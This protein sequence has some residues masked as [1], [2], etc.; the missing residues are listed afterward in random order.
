MEKNTQPFSYIMTVIWTN[1]W[2]AQ[3][4]KT[5][6]KARKFLSSGIWERTHPIC[7]SILP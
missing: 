4:N 3:G 5:Y 7:D 1:Y 2:T 6:V